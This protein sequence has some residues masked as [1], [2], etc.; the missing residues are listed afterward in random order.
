MDQSRRF[1]GSNYERGI[2]IVNRFNCDQVYVYAMGQEPWLTYALSLRYTDES[3]PIVDSN[4][5][6]AE[7]ARRNIVAERLFGMKECVYCEEIQVS[8]SPDVGA[9]ATAG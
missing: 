4:K 3:P 9:I 6:I 8:E 1:S 5:L 2:D 7:C